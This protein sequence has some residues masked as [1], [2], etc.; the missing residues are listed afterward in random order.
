M[1]KKKT[2]WWIAGGAAAV[3]LIALLVVLL[4]PGEDIPGFGLKRDMTRDE[5]KAAMEK[6]GMTCV[7]D[8]PDSDR[9]IFKGK[10]AIFGEQPSMVTVIPA[11]EEITFSFW[12]D[13]YPEYYNA[14]EIHTTYSDLRSVF[15]RICQAAGKKLGNSG[16]I[17][18]DGSSMTWEKGG[19]KYQLI[20]YIDTQRYFCFIVPMGE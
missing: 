6:K 13:T 1:I 3:A 5:I 20:D 8:K 16:E 11:S 2:K 7:L 12:D 10:T 15:D 18:A 17:S 19:V 14:V 4:L 9:L